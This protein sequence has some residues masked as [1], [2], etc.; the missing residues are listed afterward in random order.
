[1]KRVLMLVQFGCAL[2]FIGW[3]VHEI[4]WESLRATLPAVSLAGAGVLLFFRFVVYALLGLRLT[5]LL[6]GRIPAVRAAA[7]AIFCLGCNNILPARMGE[8]CKIGY[9]RGDAAHS[10]PALLGTVAVERGL[11][12]LCLLGLAVFFGSAM[13]PVHPAW[14]LLGMGAFM[15]IGWVVLWK[16]A[17]L[18]ACC[19]AF[20]PFL[21]CWAEEMLDALAGIRTGGIL[22]KAGILSLCIWGCNFIHAA[23]LVNMLFPLGLSLHEVGILC[24]VLFGSSALFL[25]PGGYGLMEGAV[26][27]LLLYWGIETAYALAIALWGR[28]YYSLLP[29]ALSS[30]IVVCS[31]SHAFRCNVQRQ[32]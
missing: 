21:R 17:I 24:V 2:L 19:R 28:L 22:P 14:T 31:P 12:V 8:I 29:L 11:D 20:P 9:L 10:I 15:G 13:L 18:H 3:A 27:A 32:G 16:T 25:I 7:A 5:V 1:M 4:S 6:Q 30:V 26:T 23:L